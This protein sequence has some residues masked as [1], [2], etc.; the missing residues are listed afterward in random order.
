[1]I[2]RFA[3]P[4]I[5]ILLLLIPLFLISW[6][7]LKSPLSRIRYS[8]VD[9]WKSISGAAS[10]RPIW[11]IRSFRLLVLLLLIAAAA[12]P[13]SGEHKEIIYSKGVDIAI[14][15]DISGS[16]RALDFQPKN[17]LNVAKQVIRDFVNK[18]ENDRIG[19]VLFG[20]ESFTLCPLTLDHDLLL[21]FLDLAEIGMV[22]EKTAIGKAVANAVN[23]LRLKSVPTKSGETDKQKS[24]RMIIL[25]TDGVNNVTSKIDP[26]T[27]AK[28]AEAL[29]I[30]IYTIGVGTNGYVRF[31]DQRFPGRTIKARVQL[32]EDTLKEIADI[33]GGQYFQAT[34]SNALKRIFDIIDKMEK[35]DIESLKYTRYSEQ[36]IWP[37]IAA[38]LLLL[39]E[40]IL[41]Q[42]KY[43]RFP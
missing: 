21:E 3:N 7:Y 23:R 39:L 15:L 26:I 29:D 33:T 27:A 42:T 40:I 30:R 9:I 4:E 36:F 12:R 41:A 25:C 2:F 14:A 19:L 20:S 18:R 11:I 8:R 38:A 6:I 24:N 32:D 28:A 13:Q 22:E 31:P 16:M 34:N 37:L 17:R 10:H 35:V 5:F 1:M 43:R